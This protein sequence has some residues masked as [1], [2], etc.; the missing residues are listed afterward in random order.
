MTTY[1]CGSRCVA[2]KVSTICRTHGNVCRGKRVADTDRKPTSRAARIATASGS[3]FRRIAYER[4]C[5][6]ET[7]L[8][9]QPIL[10]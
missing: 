6:D 2:T 8:H 3:G 4:S 10:R 9:M 7:H 1:R 5:S